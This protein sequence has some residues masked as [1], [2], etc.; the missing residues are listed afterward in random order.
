[1][2][3]KKQYYKK[4][5]QKGK[6]KAIAKKENYNF[7][8]NKD[9][10]KYFHPKL[11]FP[12]R[13]LTSFTSVLNGIIAATSTNSSQFAVSMNSLVLPWAGTTVGVVTT[14]PFPNPKVLNV[15]TLYPQGYHQLGNAAGTSGMYNY[16]RVFK[17][18]I[19][20]D[21]RPV[22]PL[23]EVY[24]YAIPVGEQY[25]GDL[26]QPSSFQAGLP[27]P[28]EKNTTFGV[29][30]NPKTLKNQLDLHTLFGKTKE[31][32]DDDLSGQYGAFT[33]GRPSIDAYWIVGYQTVAETALTSPIG[34][35]VKV[36][37]W[38][39]LSNMG[40]ANLLQV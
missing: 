9:M 33:N 12:P 36:T 5:Y 25:N 35:T 11:P 10:I 16:Y 20:I 8:C 39:E 3:Y 23:D 26:L 21:F 31:Q 27:D 29:N 15:T 30:L 28:Y 18:K 13:F 4:K 7:N 17:S 34:Y 6:G 37:W 32:Y 24:V 22:N 14:V 1:M 19:E 38:T 40:G 2:A